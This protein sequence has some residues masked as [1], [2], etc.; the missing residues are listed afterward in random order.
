MQEDGHPPELAH[1]VNIAKTIPLA[2]GQN[3]AAYDCT[4]L[5]SLM[6]FL[7]KR[8]YFPSSASYI[9]AAS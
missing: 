2:T 1:A 3:F 9:V 6:Y 5:S 7:F 8:L 4:K